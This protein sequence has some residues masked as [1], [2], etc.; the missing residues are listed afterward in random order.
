MYKIHAHVA[1][2]IMAAQRSDGPA[3]S[4]HYDALLPQSGTMTIG[5]VT[6]VDRVLGLLSHAMDDLDQAEAHFEDG[7]AFCRRAGFRPELAWTSC[8]YADTLLQRTGSGD[9]G[10]ARSLLD[11]SLNISTEL[12]MR[13]LMERVQSRMDQ[14]DSTPTPAPGYP[15]GLSEREVQVLRLIAVGKS[16]PE[17][18]E[19]LVISVRTVANHVANILNKTNTINRTEAAAYATRNGL[20]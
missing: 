4:E 12:G 20:T 3:V 18:G 17:I 9:L 7:L 2:G 10:K 15:D 8:D 5:G 1:L 6:V 16:N 11:Q 13:P 14:L 19:E